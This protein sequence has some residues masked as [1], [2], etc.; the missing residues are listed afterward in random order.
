M[1]KIIK[2][3]FFETIGFE[4]IQD[5]LKSI[6]CWKATVLAVFGF[7]V[8]GLSGFIERYIW[9]DP[10]AFIFLFILIIIDFITGIVKGIKEKDFRSRRIPRTA[11]KAITYAIMLFVAFNVNK[12][13][14]YVFFWLPMSML[15]VFYMTELWSIV[16]NFSKLGMLDR[17]LVEFLKH[18]LNIKKWLNGSND[19]K[20]S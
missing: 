5:V 10:G 7:L 16:E 19:K 12:Y 6:L 11:G 17:D 2:D 8:G 1:N 9:D 14:E 3:I 15:G 18:K 4:N 13:I 20:G